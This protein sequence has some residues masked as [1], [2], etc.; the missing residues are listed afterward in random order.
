MGISGSSV[1]AEQYM[2]VFDIFVT[3]SGI[4][5]TVVRFMAASPIKPAVPIGVP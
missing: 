4:L 1:N 3:P 5:L 2:N